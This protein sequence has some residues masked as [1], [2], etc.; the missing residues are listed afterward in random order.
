MADSPTDFSDRQ[1]L[2]DGAGK[3]IKAEAHSEMAV[4][5][6]PMHV[7]SPHSAAQI[8]QLYASPA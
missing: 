5:Q 4:W 8:D 1:V 7:F 6:T 3:E 2:V